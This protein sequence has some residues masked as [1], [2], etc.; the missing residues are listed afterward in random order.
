MCNFSNCGN[1]CGCNSCAQSSLWNTGYQCI[2]RD[3]CGN[4]RVRSCCGCNTQSNCGCSNNC[5]CNNNCGCN[6]DN[7]N[8]S[9]NSR[10]NG[11]TCFTFSGNNVNSQNTGST[12]SNGDS[13]YAR[14]YGLYSGSRCPC[15]Y[16]YNYNGFDTTQ[17]T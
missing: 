16:S 9:S 12:V 8:N 6:N 15:S 5:N 13:Y 1:S 7:S 2:C 14:Q 3:G 17:T 10:G 11:F 4:I